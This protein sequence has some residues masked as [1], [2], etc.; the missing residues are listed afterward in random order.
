MQLYVSRQG[1]E[2]AS[3]A[4]GSARAEMRM[5]TDTLLPWFCS[6]KPLLAIGLARLWQEN[7]LRLDQPVSDVV[8]DFRGAGKEHLTFRQLLTHTAA[9]RPDPVY[10]VLWH[11]RDETW[12][13][14]VGAA[15]PADARP[16][17]EAYYAQFWAWFVL[18]EAI[19]RLTG[20]DYEQFLR[21]AVLRPLG[22]DDV[23]LRLSSERFET[24]RE[25]LGLVYDVDSDS[26]PQV[27]AAAAEPWQYDLHVPGVLG[28]GSAASL[29]RI[30]EALL[31]DPPVRILRPQT[32]A[33]LTAR[34]R[35]GLWDEH[36]GGFLS[37]G[38]GLIVDG[39]FFGSRC[40]SE[41]FGH[42]GMNTSFAMVDPK[43]S[44]VVAGIANGFSS[45]RNSVQRDRGLVDAVY[46]D[47]RLR[48]AASE[49][50]RIV[51]AEPDSRPGN[52]SARLEARYWKPI[53]EATSEQ[54]RATLTEMNDS[55][56]AATP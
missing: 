26:A 47:L 16:G 45:F 22:L 18:A 7:C 32:V 1:E 50:V 43:E 25:R 39:W 28:F 3:F 51:D 12:D 38:L 53:H 15:P 36:W 40:S 31:D 5:G 29:G 33:A 10:Q 24:V 19:E 55:Q 4:V 9:L 35:V 17:A 8:H 11:S 56:R 20:M 21:V 14:I 2:V 37:W 52:A 48:E 6:A 27:F 30:L 34:H 23:Y 54:I 42:I 13:A 46:E 41:T 44:L 49:P